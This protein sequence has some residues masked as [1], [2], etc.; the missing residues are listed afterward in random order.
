MARPPVSWSAVTRIRVS[1]GVGVVEVHSSLHGVAHLQHIM[2]GSSGIVCM[3][4][5]VDLTALG[6]EEEALGV[7]QQLDALLDVVGQLPLACG[8]IHGVVHGLAVGQIF[9]NDQGLACTC[10]QGSSACL[11]GD[12]IVSGLSS[13]LV[14]SSCS[15]A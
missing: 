9:G 10:G 11:R 4:G 1:L 5:P 13:H 8:G 12:H 15:S 3:A 6:H 2:D 14:S 7:I